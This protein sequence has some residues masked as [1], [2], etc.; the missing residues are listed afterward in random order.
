MGCWA[1]EGT[2]G[3]KKNSY[4][5]KQ[6]K[7]VYIQ[8]S[9]VTHACALPSLRPSLPASSVWGAAFP[10]C[11]WKRQPGPAGGNESEGEEPGT[12][13]FTVMTVTR[14]VN[15]NI[16]RDQPLLWEARQRANLPSPGQDGLNP[17]LTNGHTGSVS[18]V[19]E[20]G[21]QECSN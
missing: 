11:T 6:L 7:L 19:N 1:K 16:I 21:D 18:D 9:N 12:M 4:Q 20:W 8:F 5:F 15:R 10:S 17:L 2:W 13:S 3:V 14:R